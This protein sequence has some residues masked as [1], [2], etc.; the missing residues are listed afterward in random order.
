LEMGLLR[1]GPGSDDK[2]VCHS[3]IGCGL[4]LLMIA[5]AAPIGLSDR[6]AL[7]IQGLC[8]ALGAHAAKELSSAPLMHLAWVRLRRLSARFAVLAAAVRAGRL[9]PAR[10]ARPGVGPRPARPLPEFP[11]E[12][13]LPR[14]F[15]WLLRLAPETAAFGGQVEHF[16]ADPE[17][18]SLLAETPQAGRI[19]RPLCRMLGIRPPPALRLPR[20]ERPASSV[21]TAVS[22]RP[23]D[24][25]GSG[26]RPGSPPEVARPAA[27]WSADLA[28]ADPP[29]APRRALA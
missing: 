3:P 7:I 21:P 4:L 5:P 2:I 24:P 26:P 13:I 1:C 19:L 6:L 9:A 8:R 12:Y 29:L 10:A 20:R 25:G 16:L 11:P 22:D 15:G 18:A 23:A 14:G 28:G 27:P 17:L